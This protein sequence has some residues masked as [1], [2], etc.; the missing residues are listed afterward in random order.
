M[1][2]D[3]GDRA[4]AENVVVVLAHLRLCRWCYDQKTGMNNWYD[5]EIKDSMNVFYTDHVTDKVDGSRRGR[6]GTNKAYLP[7]GGLLYRQ[8]CLGS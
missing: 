5:R 4:G 1:F 2:R 3:P 8:K 7:S 6:E